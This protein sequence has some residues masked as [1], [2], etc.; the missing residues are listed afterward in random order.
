MNVIEQD[1]YELIKRPRTLGHY[2]PEIFAVDAGGSGDS[3]LKE[4]S[5]EEILRRRLLKEVV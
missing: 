4:L 1:G 3:I 2:A 5:E